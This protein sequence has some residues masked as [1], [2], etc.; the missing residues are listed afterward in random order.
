MSNTWIVV[1]L[2]IAVVSRDTPPQTP[3]IGIYTEDTEDP[4]S[5][6]KYSTYIAASYVKNVQMAGAQVVPLFYHLSNEQ[7][8][9]LLPK[10]NGVLFPGG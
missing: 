1:F 3:V 5:T 4:Y 8:D 6:G 10:L 7:L 9:I 2:L